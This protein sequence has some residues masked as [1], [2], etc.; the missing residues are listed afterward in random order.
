MKAPFCGGD[1]SL[2]VI[3]QSIHTINK[4]GGNPSSE[5]TDSEW[6][7]SQQRSFPQSLLSQGDP[8]RTISFFQIS[9]RIS[10]S[11]QDKDLILA[12]IVNCQDNLHLLGEFP[13]SL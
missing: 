4:N 11:Y 8:I 6:G 5:A 9:L 2:R 3:R 12:V 1:F 10:F 13:Y 7:K